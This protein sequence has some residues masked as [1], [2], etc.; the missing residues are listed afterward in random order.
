MSGTK[1][2]PDASTIATM[3]EALP[4][5]ESG[6]TA[7]YF[8]PAATPRAIINYLYAQIAEAAK[9]PEVFSGNSDGGR[10]LFTPPE[11]TDAHMKKEVQRWTALLKEAGIEPQ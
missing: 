4:G 3:D 2:L 6:S 8:A 5:V 1:R 11:E 9:D 10:P 7:G